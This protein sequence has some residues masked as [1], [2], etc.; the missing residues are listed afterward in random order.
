MFHKQHVKILFA[1]L[2]C[3]HVL[4]WLIFFQSNECET[5]SLT[6][7]TRYC[8]TKL[9]PFHHSVLKNPIFSRTIGHPEFLNFLLLGE[10]VMCAQHALSDPSHFPLT[11]AD[12]VVSHHGPHRQGQHPMYN[13]TTKQK[14]PRLLTK[15]KHNCDDFTEQ[16]RTSLDF[17]LW[18]KEI[19]SC[20]CHLFHL[21]L[22]S[23]NTYVLYL[24]TI[25]VQHLSCVYWLLD[26]FSVNC[27]LI[28][29]IHFLI[30]L[31][32]FI[33]IWRYS[34]LYSRY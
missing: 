23:S 1:L 11:N 34:L 7:C 32:F 8:S 16:T 24:A 21:S 25:R 14:A 22:T 5:F 30:E 15:E 13:R 26:S 19:P 28:S 27:F 31:L 10:D 4:N 12:V 17:Y 9:L 20:F 3:Q 29:F 6:W 2:H 18:E 33:L